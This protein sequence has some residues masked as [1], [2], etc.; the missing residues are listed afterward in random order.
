[1]E[2]PGWL[3]PCKTTSLLRELA[4]ALVWP[5]VAVDIKFKA[6]ASGFSGGG[7]SFNN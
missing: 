4:A 3:P 1:M 5:V 7:L 6:G 2:H